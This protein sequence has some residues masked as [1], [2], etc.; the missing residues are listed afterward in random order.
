MNIGQQAEIEGL[1]RRVNKSI[2]KNV[3]QDISEGDLNKVRAYVV[4]SKR[5]LQSVRLLAKEKEERE[6][7]N[8]FTTQKEQIIEKAQKLEK[9]KAIFKER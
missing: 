6:A 7:D 5:P 2:R 3:K 9:D 4:R 1:F 8:N